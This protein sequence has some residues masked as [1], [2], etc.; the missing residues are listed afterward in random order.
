MGYYYTSF[1]NY[2]MS[3][4]LSVQSHGS[5]MLCSPKA[6]QGCSQHKQNP[7]TLLHVNLCY[8]PMSHSD[9]A[10][11]P[12]LYTSLTISFF[13]LLHTDHLPLKALSSDNVPLLTTS[14]RQAY[15]QLAWL[16]K[17]AT[18]NYFLLEYSHIRRKTFPLL[19]MALLF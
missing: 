10:F 19:N 2:K 6:Y 16:H 13:L 11:Q 5:V 8:G 14:W 1:I 12:D 15:Y 17:W 18:Q 4:S 7:V 3:T 9:N